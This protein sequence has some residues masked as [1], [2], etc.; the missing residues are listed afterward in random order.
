M[1]APALKQFELQSTYNFKMF[2]RHSV[3]QT[4]DDF[5]TIH[6]LKHE[7]IDIICV[8]VYISIYNKSLSTQEAYIKV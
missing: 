5:Y 7:Y 6:R 2:V 1:Q 8:Y 3:V 4:I